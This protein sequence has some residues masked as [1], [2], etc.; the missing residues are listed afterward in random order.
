M[1]FNSLT[2][3][4]FFAVVMF[5]HSLPLPWRW[6]K[7]NLLIFS[8]LFYMAWNPPF[9]ILLW[10]STVVDWFLGKWMAKTEQKNKRV[11][12]LVASLVVNLGMLSF[13]KYGNFLLENFTWL[14]GQV[15]V[16]YVPPKMDIVLPVGISFYTFQTLSYTLDIYRGKMKPW[17]SFLDYALYVTFFPQLVA[18]PIV[19]AIDFLG[20]CATPRRATSAQLSWGLT[21][22]VIGL[23]EKVVIADGLLAPISEKLYDAS[24]GAQ[25]LDAWLGTFAFAGQIFCDFAGY[26]TCAIGV[27]LC[28]GFGIMDN[29]RFPYAAVGFS[30]FWRR[31]HISLSSWLRDYLYIPLGGNKHRARFSFL[32]FVLLGACLGGIFLGQTGISLAA[33]GLYLAFLIAHRGVL[34]NLM[35]TM[36]IGGLWHGAAFT[37]VIWGALHGLYLLGERVIRHIVPESELWKKWPIQLAMAMGTF[38]LICVTWVFFRARSFDSAF[39]IVGSMA[40]RVAEG[41]R[42]LLTPTDMIIAFYVTVGMLTVHWSMRNTTLEDVAKRTP[43]LLRAVIIAVMITLT[44][45]MPGEDRAFIYFQF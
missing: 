22:L 41:Q 27:A 11:L 9:V 43:W 12:L 21:L 40:G 8:Y 7:F 36:V 16:E 4:V 23:F 39:S 3:L 24:G 29:F 2:F 20:Q 45:M 37:F 32:H 25:F 17:T 42:S 5:A 44:V 6:R 14:M 15:G 31:W 28:L 18:G 1:L 33:G 34:N 35:L 38:L 30:D 26:S 10:I 13:Y 19:R